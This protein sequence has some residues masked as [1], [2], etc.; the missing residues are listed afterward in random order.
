LDFNGYLGY[1]KPMSDNLEK[2]SE[3]VQKALTFG[4]WLKDQRV[5]KKVS[6]E[7]IAAV[8]KIHIGQLR[9]L[10]E[11][12]EGVPPAPAFIRGFI[13]SY[14]KHIGLDESEVLSQFHKL[15]PDAVRE[16]V[17]APKTTP[18]QTYTANSGKPLRFGSYNERK[19]QLQIAHW[20][21]TKR[22]IYACGV[23]LG[24]AL[25]IFLM[26]IGKKAGDENSSANMMSSQTVSS[27]ASS[28]AKVVDQVITET[29]VST[30]VFGNVA[31]YSF[32]LVSSADCW[33]N[34]KTDDNSL[35]SFKLEKGESRKIMFNRKSKIT[36]SHPSFVKIQI[37]DS[38][39]KIQTSGSSAETLTF[40][41]QTTKLLPVS[42]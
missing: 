37:N 27:Q 3:E 17:S 32:T 34:L 25:L 16:K 26:R 20:L 5:S 31:P 14:A 9:N 2:A 24:L 4:A 13:V 7:E 42:K 23:L 36:L 15:A 41:E 19:D 39:F 21:S 29:S 33:V 8:T 12:W 6:L 10:E 30:N 38:M 22:I 40:P 1:T 11:G 18:P 28:Q 35:E